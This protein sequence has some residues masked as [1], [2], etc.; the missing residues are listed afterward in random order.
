[1]LALRCKICTNHLLLLL[2]II[3]SSLSSTASL[4][5]QRSRL[6]YIIQHKHTGFIITVSQRGILAWDISII[7]VIIIEV[8][9]RRHNEIRVEDIFIGSQKSCFI[10]S[11]LNLSPPEKVLIHVMLLKCYILSNI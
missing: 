7:I 9:Q 11:P 10:H 8:N 1:M 2:T 4:N 6:H 5:T 3:S